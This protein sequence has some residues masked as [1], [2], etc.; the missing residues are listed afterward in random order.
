M[1]KRK[2]PA[3]IRNDRAFHMEMTIAV[4]AII[5]MFLG[6]YISTSGWIE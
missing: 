4:V 6:D 5:L 2:D 1:R 3:R